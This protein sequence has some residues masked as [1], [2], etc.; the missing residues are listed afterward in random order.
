MWF[1][2]W[3]GNSSPVREPRL[4]LIPN[5]SSGQLQKQDRE[6]HYHYLVFVL[7]FCSERFKVFR[8]PSNRFR[9]SRTNPGRDFL[10]SAPHRTSKCNSER[11]F[12][13]LPASNV[14]QR[15]VPA[16]SKLALSAKGQERTSKHGA[17]LG[18][19]HHKFASN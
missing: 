6:Q 9:R 4:N 14:P 1:K 5:T 19:I 10:S 8:G 17:L 12:S 18:R 13:Y 15:P 2:A 16:Q 3:L 7:H 11:S